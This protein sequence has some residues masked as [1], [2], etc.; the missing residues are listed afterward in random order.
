MVGA[1]AGSQADQPAPSPP[2]VTSSTSSGERI[3]AQR[4][5]GAGVH[6]V[7]GV[8]L[9][10][11]AARPR[12]RRRGHARLL[13]DVLAHVAAASSPRARQKPRVLGAE[14]ER[15]VAALAGREPGRVADRARERAQ[16][17]VPRSRSAAG[18]AGAGPRSAPRVTVVSVASSSR[19][20]TRSG[21]HG[22]G[23]GSSAKQSVNLPGW[24]NDDA[25]D[26]PGLEPSTFIA[27]SRS[28]RPIVAF[29]RLP[30]PS[31]LWRAFMPISCRDRAADD[32]AQ[33]RA[34]GARQ[35][36]VQVERLVEH[37]LQRGDDDREVL[38]PAA[39]HH[40]VDRRLLERHAAAARRQ[41]AD[42]HVRV[43]ASTT[44]SIASHAVGRGRDD[45]QPVG[46]AAREER[47]LDVELL[48]DQAV[49]HA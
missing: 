33:R 7:L 40:G 35:H 22:A 14:H 11:H 25:S 27:T 26:S 5:V 2:A 37:R 23:G 10:L 29:A 28:A 18:R 31:T 39:R 36:R 9:Q 48:H 6:V 41:E 24:P 44:S 47:L 17:V 46:P 21:S 3:V 20:A 34:A 12:A 42:Q 45:R 1:Q 38:G 49:G 43:V 32:R 15:A 19:A 4:A 13:V 8:L 30:G 16:D